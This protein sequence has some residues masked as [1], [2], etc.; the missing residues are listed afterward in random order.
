MKN[1]LM[2]KNSV[3]SLGLLLAIFLSF[4]SYGRVVAK[5]DEVTGNLTK[6]ARSSKGIGRELIG[7]VAPDFTLESING[8]KYQL[9]SVRGKVVLLDF[10]HTY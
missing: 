10:W 5:E 9:S 6:T 1:L 4:S 7:K 8:K 2:K 3:C